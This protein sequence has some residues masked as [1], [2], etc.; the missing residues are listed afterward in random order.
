MA[1]TPTATLQ[2]AQIPT[3][4]GG[5]LGISL[6]R[7]TLAGDAATEDLAT[8]L[9]GIANG[10]PAGAEILAWING[11]IAA[12][13]Y[14]NDAGTALALPTFAH[15]AQTLRYL[16]TDDGAVAAAVGDVSASAAGA[17]DAIVIWA[18]Q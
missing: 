18:Q 13:D 3:T 6:V 5:S 8:Q 7:Y 2:I 11:A 4:G 1:F 16:M 15:A 10:L 12:T 17:G 9:V 14:A